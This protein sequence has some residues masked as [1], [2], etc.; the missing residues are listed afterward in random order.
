MSTL[1]LELL[2][3]LWYFSLSA[4]VLASRAR[5]IY[6]ISSMYD[7]FWGMF[8]LALKNSDFLVKETV[9][10]GRQVPKNYF[11]LLKRWKILRTPNWLA[12]RGEWWGRK[13]EWG[14]N[15]EWG[16]RDWGDGLPGKKQWNGGVI[17]W[18]W[19]PVNRIPFMPKLA[20]RLISME[21]V[22]PLYCRQG[23]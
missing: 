23:S 21:M 18:L 14:V 7:F 9:P 16:R 15:E 11:L 22:A 10:Q 5:K 19:S 1:L 13:A 6:H 17:V 4:D 12:S 20:S 8:L 3:Q 2:L